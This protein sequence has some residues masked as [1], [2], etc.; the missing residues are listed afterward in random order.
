[1]V[2]ELTEPDNDQLA[3][4]ACR[5]QPRLEVA[6]P[7]ELSSPMAVKVPKTPRMERLTIRFAAI[8]GP[9]VHLP[10]PPALQCARPALQAIA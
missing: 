10:G 2:G 7:A 3:A 4:D 9:V 5:V 6:A 1:M 8:C